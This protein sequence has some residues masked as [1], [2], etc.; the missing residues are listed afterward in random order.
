M[1]SGNA[2]L[3]GANRALARLGLA[4]VFFRYRLVAQP[5]AAKPLL[6]A[7]RAAGWE[8]RQLAPGDAALA[9]MPLTGAKLDERFAQGAVCLAVF[10]DNRMRAYL[11]LCFGAYDEDEVRCRF[12]PTP[13]GRTAWDFDVYVFP[14]DRGTLAFARL[15]D[16]ANALMRERGVD[17]TVSRVSA[18]NAP[19]LSSHRRLGARVVG[20]ALFVRLGPAQLMLSDL[21]PRFHLSF[22]KAA[23]PVLR[24]D[25][26]GA[27]G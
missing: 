15:W 11:W 19:S 13:S 26:G 21:R 4:P 5:V 27:D 22:P 17:W 20:D 1:G 25:A 14:E 2:L 7:R 24:P 3:Y 12:T 6:P 9:A 18:F 8:V 23:A 10:R 16:A